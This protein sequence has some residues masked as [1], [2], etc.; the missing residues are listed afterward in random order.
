MWQPFLLSILRVGKKWLWSKQSIEKKKVLPEEFAIRV[1]TPVLC[2]AA[3]RSFRTFSFVSL[4]WLFACLCERTKAP[5]LPRLGGPAGLAPNDASSF[6]C[7][8]CPPGSAS[9]TQAAS[10]SLGANAYFRAFP[11]CW[12]SSPLPSPAWMALPF[13]PAI[14]SQLDHPF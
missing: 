10:A 4:M 12:T 5:M 2:P 8:W 6:R 3:N 1:V 11:W 7:P 9:A 14:Y 13:H